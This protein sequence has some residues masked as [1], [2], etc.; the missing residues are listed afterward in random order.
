LDTLSDAIGREL[1]NVMKIH[2]IF[3]A[4][5]LAAML[6]V[7]SCISFDDHDDRPVTTTVTKETVVPDPL[8]SS[9]VTQTTETT[10]TRSRY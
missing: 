7:S 10:T 8:T 2:P 1:R 3:E 4:L 6:V 9:T 5:S